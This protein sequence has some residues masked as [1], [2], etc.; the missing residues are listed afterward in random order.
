MNW[1]KE[2]VIIYNLLLNQNQ[3][4]KCKVIN[5]ELIW[6]LYKELQFF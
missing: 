6:E 1:N 2:T 5:V 4:L 3:S